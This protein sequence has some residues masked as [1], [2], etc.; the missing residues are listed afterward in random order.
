M[1]PTT[2]RTYGPLHL[3]DLEPHRFEDLVRQLIYDFR[4]WRQL[5]ATGRGGGDDGFDVRGHEV[6]SG[7]GE[8]AS[9]DDEDTDDIGGES[10][11]PDRLWLIQC[12]RERAIG[13]TKLL[14]YLDGL[15]SSAGPIDALLFVG[16]CDFSKDARDAF[17]DKARGMGLSEAHLWGKGELEDQLFPAQERSP[18]V[19]LFRN[20]AS[21]AEALRQDLNQSALDDP[22]ESQ[23]IFAL[24]QRRAGQRC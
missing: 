19:R 23:E 1:T 22:K 6:V 15:G 5:E 4:S 12:K 18:L 13:K 11:A 14:K 21:I 2:T 3:E 9:T 7:L 10:L 20:L 8:V 17:R 24:I 16:A